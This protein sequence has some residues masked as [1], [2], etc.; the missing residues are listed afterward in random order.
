MMKFRLDLL[1]HLPGV[2]VGPLELPPPV[3]VERVL[4]LLTEGLHLQSFG[5][6]LLLQVVHFLAEVAYL[7]GLRFYDAQLTL[8]VGYLEFEEADI[9]E[10]LL[11]LNFTL[12]EG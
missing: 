10:A 4:E 8:Q 11:V 3:V 12:A 1:E 9:F 7:G 2:G 5:E 6:Q